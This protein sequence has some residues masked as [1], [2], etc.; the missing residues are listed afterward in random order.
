MSKDVFESLAP[1]QQKAITDI[2][3][4]MEW[5]APRSRG[6]TGGRQGL[7]REGRRRCG[8]LAEDIAKWR[9]IAEESAWKD[10]ASKSAETAEVLASARSVA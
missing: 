5:S 3:Q 6:I 10:F 4:E 8:F 7:R 2:G 1:E 9:A